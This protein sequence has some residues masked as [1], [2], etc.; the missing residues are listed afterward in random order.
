M[1]AYSGSSCV[2]YQRPL[3]SSEKT[4]LGRVC[5]CVCAVLKF[6]YGGG[7]AMQ[8][9][10]LAFWLA[11]GVR[12]DNFRTTYHIK[13]EMPNCTSGFEMCWVSQSVKW[14]KLLL[15]VFIGVSDNSS[16]HRVVGLTTSFDNQPSV[17]SSFDNQ[18]TTAFKAQQTHTKKA[19]L[20][21]ALLPVI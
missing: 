11:A 12:A 17:H 1:C 2:I 15:H 14:K 10:V 3:T 4:W 18:P 13:L 5:V 20:K 16:V 8:E 21:H 9:G 7:A 6:Y 19:G